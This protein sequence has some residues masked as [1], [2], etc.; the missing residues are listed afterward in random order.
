MKMCKYMEQVLKAAV[1][2]NYMIK[3]YREISGQA[4]ETGTSGNLT[5]LLLRKA[6]KIL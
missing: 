2:N 3:G 6:L 4:T 1:Y 5:Y